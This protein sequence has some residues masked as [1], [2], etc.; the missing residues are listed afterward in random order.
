VPDDGDVTPARE[1]ATGSAAGTAPAPTGVRGLGLA[2][3]RLERCMTLSEVAEVAA[4]MA[5]PL[6]DA[7]SAAI[8]RIR[9][10]TCSVLAV[11]PTPESDAEKE[12]ARTAFRAED[13]PALRGLIRDRR[14]WVAHARE[15]L[16]E[17]DLAGDPVEIAGL[18]SMDRTSALASPIVVNGQVW[19]QVYASRGGDDELFG[20]DDIACAEVLAVLVASAVARVDLEDQVRH[21]IADDPLTGLGN[22]RVADH[23]AD[24]ALETGLETC[25]VMCDVDGLK[26]VND[27]LGHD[28]GDDLLR[29][30]ADVLRRVQ[31]QLPGSTAARL[32][33]DEFCIVTAGIPRA[34]VSQA[35]SSTVKQFAL[36]HGAAISWGIASSAGGRVEQPRTL[37]RRADAAQYQA[38][39]SRARAALARRRQI[40]EQA[41]TVDRLIAAGVAAIVGAQTGA[42]TR[43]C[44]LAA[45]ATS[46]LGGATWTVLRDA[47]DGVPAAIAR[48]GTPSADTTNVR[49]LTV[50]HAPWSV[51]VETSTAGPSEDTLVDSLQALVDVAVHGAH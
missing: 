50:E 25:I 48:G 34:E 2:A 8:C 12:L 27:E 40:A 47:G 42:V 41:V 16:I 5:H 7:R 45:A 31:D 17:A 1:R 39:R 26:R 11:E 3:H 4:A 46:S 43:L 24:A 35:I 44:A 9:Q 6:L 20:V 22:R 33:G 21:L 30:V 36:P 32:G 14:S 13:R 51:Q 23:A 18:R 49:S 19:G 10:E 37:F 38:K 29:S 15:D 28:A